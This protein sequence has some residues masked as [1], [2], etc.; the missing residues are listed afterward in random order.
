M[1]VTIARSCESQFWLNINPAALALGLCCSRHTF[2]A[3]WLEGCEAIIRTLK[4]LA[5]AAKLSLLSIKTRKP[6]WD[7]MSLQAGALSHIY[8]RAQYL[9]SCT[10][11]QG[12]SLLNTML[13]FFLLLL[14]LLLTLTDSNIFKLVERL[15][16]IVSVVF[17]SWPYT[18]IIQ[19]CL[20]ES[21][22]Y[23]ER[24]QMQEWIGKCFYAYPT[25]HMPSMANSWLV[26]FLNMRASAAHAYLFKVCC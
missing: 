16:F 22:W 21:C 1:R 9:Q 8:L 6:R 14:E 23:K 15:A 7:A 25:W 26:S 13:I 10:L 18:V 5:K 19:G 4:Y 3:D 11:V 2:V 12:K 24:W 17:L 20:Q